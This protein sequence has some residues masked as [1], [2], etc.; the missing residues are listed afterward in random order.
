MNPV[1]HRYAGALY[2]LCLEQDAV[3]D[4]C[5]NLGDFKDAVAAVPSLG[6]ILRRPFVLP[7]ELSQALS[8]IA[9]LRSYHPLCLSFLSFMA[10]R[11]RS[12]FLM[13]AIDAFFYVNDQKSGVQSVVVSSAFPLDLKQQKDIRSAVEAWSGQTSHVTFDCDADLLGGIVMRHPLWVFDGSLK[14][15]LAKIQKTVKGLSKYGT[16]RG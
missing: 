7:T 6:D 13:G 1:A 16:A 11:R 12:R 4:I 14:G 10:S 2:E 15:Q 8:A 9:T 3:H 5:L